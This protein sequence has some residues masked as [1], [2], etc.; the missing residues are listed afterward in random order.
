MS[1]LRGAKS[2]TGGSSAVFPQYTGIQ[3][4]TSA[5]A[6]P[7]PITYGFTKLGLNVI[8]Y[9]DFQAQPHYA[10][11]GN[12][13]QTITG[14]SYT[15]SLAFGFCEGPIT[16]IGQIFNGNSSSFFNA[17]SPNPLGWSLSDWN[18]MSLYLGSATQTPWSGYGTITNPL[19]SPALSYAGIAYSIEASFSLNSGAAVGNIQFEIAGILYATGFNSIDADPALVIQDFL[20]NPQYG[21]GFPSAELDTAKLLGVSGSSSVQTYC[22]AQG[23]AFSPQIVQ[24]EAANS[25][26]TRWLQLLNCAAFYS[27]GLLKIVPYGDLGLTGVDSTVWV[28]P[29]SVIANLTDNNFLTKGNDDP[30]K[31]ERVDP[32]NLFTAMTIEVLNRVGVNVASSMFVQQ[33]NSFL[34][35]VESVSGQG[36]GGSASQPQG[37][38]QYNP[39]PV[40]ARDQAMIQTV[41]LRMGDT[42]TAHEI[43]DLD[44]ASRIIQ[45]ILQRQLYIRTKFKFSLSWEFCLLDPMDVVTITDT[46]L[47][48]NAKTVRITSITENDDFT[49]D[50]E[51]EDFVTGVSTPGYNLSSGIN[52]G[53]I[54]SAT[55]PEPVDAFFIYEP[56]K[57]A[58]GGVAQIWFGASGG[59][60]GVPDPNWGGCN[61]WYSLDGTSY[62]EMGTIGGVAP[63]GILTASYPTG[64]GFDTTD[65][66]SVN[67][68]QSGAPLTSTSAINAQTGVANLA[69][70]GS[71]TSAELIGFETATLTGANAYNLTNIQRG[72]FGTT[73]ATWAISTAFAQMSNILQVNLPANLVGKTIYFK[74]QSFNNQGG[75]TQTLASCTAY[76]YASTGGGY[77]VSNPSDIV[78]PSGASMT[79]PITI[80][81]GS[82]VLSV[83]VQNLATL[84]GSTGYNVDPQ[85]TSSGGAGPT[86]GT[87]GT[88]TAINGASNTFTPGGSLLWSNA[89]QIVLTFQG[90]SATGGSIKV[91]VSY[92]QN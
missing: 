79:I 63:L 1:L 85:Y 70:L 62:T 55:V 31:I 65:T 2:N 42:V 67:L 4:P 90:G 59:V 68:A 12:G 7:I 24:Q 53:P 61:V 73:P 74:F 23:L 84:T 25:V 44:I 3:L 81:A 21:A 43:C 48:L 20:T 40:Y 87:W 60:G 36:G 37:Q 76:T 91:S 13:G 78:T 66:L 26:L 33:Y 75:G 6:L 71:G 5:C 56:P 50:I 92:A 41:G 39:T 10:S 80:P 69:L 15:A 14:Y 52:Y 38:P 46:Y 35:N 22:H 89:T 29:T 51:A 54:N 88:N 30:V 49:L 16:G 8:Y 86:T 82:Y 9:N 28:A 83:T 57:A 19:A 17:S 34:A 45:T 58:S 27:G 32:L 64:S 47:G 11:N 77:Q 18:Q 72:M